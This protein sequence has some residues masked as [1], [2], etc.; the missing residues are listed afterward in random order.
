MLEW[1]VLTRMARRPS[2]DRAQPQLTW[3]RRL[4]RINAMLRGLPALLTMLAFTAG[5]PAKAGGAVDFDSG[6][7][8]PLFARVIVNRL[9]H[10][11]FGAGLVE[12]PNDFGFNGG[13]PSHP[14]LLDCL[15]AE[16]IRKDW[17]VKRLHRLIVTSHTYRHLSRAPA[18]V[19]N[20]A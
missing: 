2:L 7:H 17:S 11:H 5:N 12:T 4:S 6:P 18:L 9:W 16:L 1:Y 14:E 10:Y 13:R 3:E 8:N 19:G 15:A 20:G